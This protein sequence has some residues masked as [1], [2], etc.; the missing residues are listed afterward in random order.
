MIPIPKKDIEAYMQEGSQAYINKLNNNPYPRTS[1]KGRLW[2]R[3][4]ANAKAGHGLS[5]KA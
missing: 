5:A 3:G 1:D 2:A 4:Y